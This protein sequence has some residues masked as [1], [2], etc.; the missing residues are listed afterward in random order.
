MNVYVHAKGSLA[1]VVV[2]SDT[3]HAARLLNDEIKKRRKKQKRPKP[4]LIET[5]DLFP[6]DVH[7]S[8]AAIIADD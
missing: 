3:G 1:A 4:N 5:A 6:V 7:R 2:A 8:R